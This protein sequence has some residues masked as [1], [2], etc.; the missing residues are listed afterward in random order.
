MEDMLRRPPT[1][2]VPYLS[3]GPT[4]LSPFPSVGGKEFYQF[5]EALTQS[6]TKDTRAVIFYLSQ[7]N[8]GKQHQD[9]LKITQESL[10]EALSSYSG[11][12]FVA[13]Q[14]DIICVYTHKDNKIIKPLAEKI[15]SFFSEDVIV[16]PS[17]SAEFFMEY[18]LAKKYRDF[19][20][21]VE[22]V[23]AIQ[24][25]YLAPQ[26]ADKWIRSSRRHIS[27]LSPA[28]FKEVNDKLTKTDISACIRSQPICKLPVK[29]PE[30]YSRELYVQIS[31]LQKAY[32]PTVDLLTDPLLFQSLTH[33][34]DL[35]VLKELSRPKSKHSKTH[36]NLNFNITTLLSDAFLIWDKNRTEKERKNTIIELQKMD[37]F[38]D[39]G[40]YKFISNLLRLKG[41][42]I[43]LDGMTHLTLPLIDW[44]KLNVDYV[45]L[46]WSWEML[47]EEPLSDALT[48]ADYNHVILAHCDTP[49]AITWGK[50]Q[51]IKLFQGWHV[52][53]LMMPG[54][55]A[56]E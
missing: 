36:L 21:A 38:M 47:H 5:I 4:K 48:K 24:K 16:T 26:G 23:V 44:R 35:A 52:D 2:S 56:D 20:K 6:A 15:R 19:Y 43:C 14:G 8:I 7:L 32:C 37:I 30:I 11:R 1:R 55:S 40:A 39:I 10:E 41:Y 33:H 34:L 13:Q 46:Y 12:I 28:K 18:D 9:Y 49:E 53:Q 42:K 3:Y 51:G 31:D 50:K 45:K 17:A 25:D 29:E 22:E 27:P 54:Y